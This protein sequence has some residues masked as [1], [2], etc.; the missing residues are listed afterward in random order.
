MDTDSSYLTLEEVLAAERDLNRSAYRNVWRIALEVLAWGAI[1]T[2][3]FLV[4]TWLW[5]FFEPI[6]SARVYWAVGVASF[7]FFG[8]WPLIDFLRAFSFHRGTL[9]TLKARV[10]T[11][12][13]V[14]RPNPVVNTDLAHKTAQGRL[15]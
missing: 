6:K 12:E 15:P 5:S 3:A 11:G 1:T 9:A 14:P 7:L 8:S 13:N 2:A 10:R 4:A